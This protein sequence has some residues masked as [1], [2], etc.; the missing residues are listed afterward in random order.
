MSQCPPHHRK[1]KGKYFRDDSGIHDAIAQMCHQIES[2]DG[3]S[4][5]GEYIDTSSN[6]CAS[7]TLY[8]AFQYQALSA[9]FDTHFMWLR[10]KV[11]KN[12][13]S[14]IYLFF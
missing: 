3:Q 9:Q 13:D 5:F 8:I 2:D 7:T 4:T 1:K 11:K 6:A 14:V 10:K 12:K